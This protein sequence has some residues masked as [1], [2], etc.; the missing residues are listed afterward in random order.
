MGKDLCIQI[1]HGPD[2]QIESDSERVLKKTA[3]SE[4]QNSASTAKSQLL[5]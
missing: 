5:T 4:H 2:Y 3:F 1:P